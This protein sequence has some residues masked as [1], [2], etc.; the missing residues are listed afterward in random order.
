MDGDLK[1]SW[2]IYLALFARQIYQ[3]LGD[4][5]ASALLAFLLLA[6]TP[7]PFIFYKCKSLPHTTPG[8]DAKIVRWSSYSREEQDNEAGLCYMINLFDCIDGAG[9]MRGYSSETNFRQDM[10]HRHRLRLH[11]DLS[12]SFM[13]V[14]SL[15]RETHGSKHVGRY[16]A[17]CGSETGSVEIVKDHFRTVRP[18]CDVD[19]YTSHPEV[20][21][22]QKPK[23][24]V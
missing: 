15:G 3:N 13:A 6:M 17:T 23:V 16:G 24:H 4:R 14:L 10:S 7:L 22:S 11:E 19:N 1:I 8:Q 2:L 12:G 20:S 5:W 18:R 21:T 9:D